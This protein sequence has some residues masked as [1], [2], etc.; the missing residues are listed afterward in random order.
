MNIAIRAATL[1]CA[2]SRNGQMHA[3]SDSDGLYPPHTPAA[4]AERSLSFLGRHITLPY[5]N[6]FAA[7]KLS[8]ADLFD[9]LYQ[10]LSQAALQAGWPSES[11]ANTPIF[12]G[13]TAYLMSEREQML[14]PGYVSEIG[15]DTGRHSLT[16]VAEHF[17]HRLGNPDIFSFATSC[18]SSANAL[19]YAVKMLRAGWCQRALVLGFEN[20]NALTFEHFHAM[21]LLADTPAYT[22]FAQT[23]GFICGEAAACLALECGSGA[24]TLR[25]IAGGTDT[26]GLTHTDSAAVKRV[27]QAALSDAAA[28]PGQIRLVKTHGIGSAAADEAEAAALH[29][30][31]P[32]T[33]RA[34]L[35]PFIGHTLGAAAIIETAL[36]LS[37]LHQ[38]ALPPLPAA[39][40]YAQ[41]DAPLAA[42]GLTLDSGLYLMNFFGFG[43]SN[44]SIILEQHA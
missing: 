19:C 30:L 32:N 7:A 41:T 27:M 18:T 9:I 37:C 24:A 11:L 15:L 22:P 6:T 42:H 2:Q 43:G 44:T 10:H 4:P 5:F 17:H 26:L 25:G 23:G 20:F 13:S 34:A 38:S 33:P 12:I 14:N 3:F 28:Q 36:L 21:G 8:A 35:K 29:A 16:H 39:A 31:L 1:Q 40:A